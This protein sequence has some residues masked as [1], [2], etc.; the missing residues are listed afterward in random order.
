MAAV[1]KEDPAAHFPGK[2]HL[3]GDHH[4]GHALVGQLLHDFQH[5]AHH[6]GVQGGGGL[7]EQHHLGL[8]GQSPDNGDTLLLAAGELGGIGVR[9]LLQAHPLEQGGGGVVGLGLA[10]QLGADGSQG[11]VL[12]N[13][14]VGEEIEVLEH[15]AHLPPDQVDVGLGVGDGG[16]LKGDGA[17][18]GGLQ[19]VEAAQEGG[20]ARAGGPDD[21][22]FLPGIDVLGDVVQHQ[23]VP[24]GL[25]QMFNVYHFDAAS[26][27][28][29]PAAR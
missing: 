14:H 15:H 1:H 20:L 12:P 17:L 3:V 13:G 28:E 18:G 29:Y 25:G 4:H 5:L 23:M 2:A 7:V 22:H 21:D 27:P 16:A 9:L 11:N 8:H 10:H 6:F 26:F 24:E 19:Q